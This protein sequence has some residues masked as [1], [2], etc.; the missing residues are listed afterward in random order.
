MLTAVDLV[1]DD[2]A[3]LP[4]GWR[5]ELQECR[6]W[7]ARRLAIGWEIGWADYSVAAMTEYLL[8]QVKLLVDGPLPLGETWDFTPPDR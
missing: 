6:S 8:G 1:L 7:A 4:A 3:G 5:T 2:P